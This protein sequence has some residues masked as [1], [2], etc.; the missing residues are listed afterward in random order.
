[1]DGEGRVLRI[2]YIIKAAFEAFGPHADMA[3]KRLDQVFDART[4]FF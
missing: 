3:S 4:K 2:Q 1:M